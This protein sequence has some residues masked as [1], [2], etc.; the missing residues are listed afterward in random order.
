LA[1]AAETG[2]CNLNSKFPLNVKIN[3]SGSMLK[4]DL[5]NDITFDPF[6]SVYA[7]QYL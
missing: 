4:E 7:R 1:E 6:D 3:T 5:S 2:F